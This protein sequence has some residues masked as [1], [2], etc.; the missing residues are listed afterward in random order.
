VPKFK[1]DA[2][3]RAEYD[4]EGQRLTVW[5]PDGQTRVYGEVPLKIWNGLLSARSKGGFYKLRIVDL[6]PV[7]AG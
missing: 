6:F 2:I 1:S 3:K 7:E 5:F 4:A